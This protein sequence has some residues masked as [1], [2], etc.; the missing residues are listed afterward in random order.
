MKRKLVTVLLLITLSASLISCG[1]KKSEKVESL[2]ESTEA[3]N[4]KENDSV[5]NLA[6]NSEMNTEEDKQNVSEI[7]EDA[8]ANEAE[9][10]LSDMESYLLDK[11]VLSGERVQMS[12][13]LIGAI[14][15]FKYND[16]IGEIYEY[17]TN[18]EEYKKL[19]NGESISIEGME[20]Y[21]IKAVS[22]NGKFVLFG[23]GVSQDLID[24]FNLFE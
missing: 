9:K 3:D 19:S 7:A 6:D 14:S 4:V 23:E 18:S 22:V 5:E 1:T 24:A 2:K 21:A 8:S 20:G 12:A 16:S 15:G 11:G 13:A 17:D 10:N